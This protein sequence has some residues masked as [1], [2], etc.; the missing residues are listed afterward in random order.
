VVLLAKRILGFLNVVGTT[1]IV[2]SSTDKPDPNDW[3]YTTVDQQSQ[4]CPTCA[5]ASL[6]FVSAIA[7][8]SPGNI[9][10]SRVLLF[11]H[12]ASCNRFKANCTLLA[13]AD[14]NQLLE[15]NWRGVEFWTA[16]GWS[17]SPYATDTQP[18]NVPSWETTMHWS[19]SLKLW[20]TFD[21]S[22]GG[23][24]SLWSATD[25]T[26]LWQSTRVY[27]IPAPFAGP[28]TNGSWLCYAAKS[29]PEF[30]QEKMGTGHDS[31]STELVFS[32]ICNTWGGKNKTL[33]QEFQR[34]GMSLTPSVGA[35]TGIRGY[36]FRFMRVK[37][38][39]KQNTSA[40][41]QLTS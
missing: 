30:A 19:S 24:V 6:N 17:S 38:S 7:W 34:G 20:Y 39:P 28:H 15:H 21:V 3:Q 40:T 22:V 16:N 13:R 2:L 25:P 26:A 32:Y 8:A 41:L 18:L 33:Q 9:S 14:F 1:S 11:G 4:L 29:H 31:A 10:D 35:P 5:N 12:D 23:D 37:I 36:W 27:S